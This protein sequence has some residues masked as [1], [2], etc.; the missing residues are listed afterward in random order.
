MKEVFSS[1]TS[2]VI[3]IPDSPIQEEKSSDL[4]SL[5]SKSNLLK[6]ILPITLTNKI[7]I[8]D[9]EGTVKLS[10]FPIIIDKLLSSIFAYSIILFLLIIIILIIVVKKLWNT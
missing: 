10:G 4:N 8:G 3:D 7:L 5:N 1:S 9:V 6:S 2:S